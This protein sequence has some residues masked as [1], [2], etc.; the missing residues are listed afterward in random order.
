M[1]LYRN[2]ALFKNFVWTMAAT[3]HLLFLGF[4]FTDRDFTNILGDCA[5]DLNESGMHHFALV[6]LRPEEND[7]QMRT[8]MNDRYLV[9]P[10]FY[11]VVVNAGGLPNHDEFVG[12]IN[13]ISV[14]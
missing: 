9:D 2:N 1:E 14:A 12:I 7:G 4:S 13:A 11:N 5:R 8:L 10:I 3:K 6:G